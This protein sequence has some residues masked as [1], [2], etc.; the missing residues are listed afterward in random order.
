MRYFSDSGDMGG[1][2]VDSVRDPHTQQILVVLFL[3][4]LTMVLSRL[5]RWR[6]LWILGRRKIICGGGEIC[7][8]KLDV[9]EMIREG[10][11]VV[12]RF[13]LGLCY[14]GGVSFFC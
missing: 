1:R 8:R 3:G 2:R 12:R 6:R 13:R 9:G 14:L 7:G 11:P 4:Y 5:G 10:R